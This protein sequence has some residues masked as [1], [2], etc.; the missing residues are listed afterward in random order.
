MMKKAVALL[1]VTLMVFSL[2]A[3][4]SKESA[5]D[6]DGA[7][8]TATAKD[9]PSTPI[10]DNNDLGSVIDK[11][12]PTSPVKGS[13]LDKLLNAFWKIKYF[14]R[15]RYSEYDYTKL[16]SS[17]VDANGV[18][19]KRVYANK[20]VI[21]NPED[22]TLI[23]GSVDGEGSG[24]VVKFNEYGLPT[25][26]Y[27]PGSDTAYEA[28]EYDDEGRLIARQMW[29]NDYTYEYSADGKTVYEKVDGCVLRVYESDE[30]GS[31]VSVISYSKEGDFIDKVY[32][33]T[34][35]EGRF[36]KVYLIYN[37][38]EISVTYE[39]V[40]DEKGNLLKTIQ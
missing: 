29:P 21:Y 36:L 20:S 8:T 16:I 13:Q 34:D 26:M 12:D 3:C 30:N 7:T 2:A 35:E 18:E 17:E 10:L 4:G 15:D 24:S 6:E 39:H 38:G 22:N 1:L 37:S 40:Y 28:Y 5:K 32:V 19:I 33:D 27:P 11:H 9:K 23:I 31:L 25:G 14:N